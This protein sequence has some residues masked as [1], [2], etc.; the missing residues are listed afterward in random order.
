[1]TFQLSTSKNELFIWKLFPP[2]SKPQNQF[3]LVKIRLFFQNWLS[4]ILVT[5]ST[6]RKKL[7]TKEP[8][9]HWQKCLKNGEKWFPLAAKS[10][11]F[12]G[13]QLPLAKIDFKDWISPNFSNDF[14]QQKESSKI[15]F[16]Q[17]E[18]YLLKSGFPLISSSRKVIF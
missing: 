1:M 8:L 7:L 9:Y 17:Q 13:N 12:T 15:C 4:L 5:V 16:H 14:H 11:S 10:V 3:S 18:C 6:Q 2:N